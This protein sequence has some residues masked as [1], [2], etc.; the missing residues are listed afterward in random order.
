MDPRT[1]SA[2]TNALLGFLVGAIFVSL[3]TGRKSHLPKGQVIAPLSVQSEDSFFTGSMETEEPPKRR[4]GYVY[5]STA[6]QELYDKTWTEGGY[7]RQSCWGCRFATDVIHKVS[8]DAVVE[9]AAP[10]A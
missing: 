6:Y 1:R 7:P 10:A 9:S 5:K 3:F 8:R 4:D 2:L